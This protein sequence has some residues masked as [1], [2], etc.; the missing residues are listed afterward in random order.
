MENIKDVEVK[1]WF[2]KKVESWKWSIMAYK[3]EYTIVKETDKA[4]L[5]N[6]LPKDKLLNSKKPN[7]YDMWF[8]KSAIEII[9]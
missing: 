4:I 8:P 2:V 9:K 6:V 1:D 7:G 5:I 3:C